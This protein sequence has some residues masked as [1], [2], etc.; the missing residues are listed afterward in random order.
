M[1]VLL[2]VLATTLAKGSTEI[3]YL[4]SLS[5]IVVKEDT[6][7]PEWKRIDGLVIPFFKD[8]SGLDEESRNQALLLR[9]RF[10]SKGVN[11]VADFSF[12]KRKF[13]LDT[14]TCRIFVFASP[15]H[16]RKWWE[17]KYEFPGWEEK[18]EKHPH[19]NG[20]YLD[21]KSESNPKRIMLLSNLM[22]SSHHI[23]PGDEH[24][25]LLKAILEELRRYGV[26]ES[27]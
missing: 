6:L 8:L 20:F 19:P 15:G 14:A 18:Y 24:L 2:V 12:S 21:S 5:E 11:G 26:S 1:V 7:G 4:P 27:G 9:D 17:Q 3:V 25:A 22:I 23:Q 16:A 13:P 10:L